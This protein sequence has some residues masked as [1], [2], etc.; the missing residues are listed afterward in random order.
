MT[1]SSHKLYFHIVFDK[2][3]KFLLFL[4]LWSPGGLP[5]AGCCGGDRGWDGTGGH[6]P[7]VRCLG[8]GHFLC[9]VFWVK[10]E[11]K[12][13]APSKSPALGNPRPTFLPSPCP[14]LGQAE[15]KLRHEL[16][17]G[18]RDVP[19]A[20]PLCPHVLFPCWQHSILRQSGVHGVRAVSSRR[21]LHPLGVPGPQAD[22]A[23]A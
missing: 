8:H 19:V 6:G 2:S 20:L 12:A 7:A 21:V 16:D 18:P 9:D 5:R 3:I 13:A 4:F 17:P 23:K 1:P 14:T 22:P 10:K 15:G 11:I